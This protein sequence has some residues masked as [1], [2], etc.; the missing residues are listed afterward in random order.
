MMTKIKSIGEIILLFSLLLLASCTT[1]TDE[2]EIGED[3]N[4]TQIELS[5]GQVMAIS[6]ASNPSTGFGWHIA[7]VDEAILEQVG[8]SEFVQEPSD[9]QT[10]GVGGMETLRFEAVGSGTTTLLLTYDQAWEDVPPEDT[11]TV[12]IVVP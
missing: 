5:L 6:L 1:T 10:V 9:A 7:E 2:I 4:G 3:D 12:T 8:E 11:F